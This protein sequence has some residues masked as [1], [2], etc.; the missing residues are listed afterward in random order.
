M[1]DENSRQLNWGILYLLTVPLG[2]ALVH[3]L[4]FSIGSF[5]VSGWMWLLYFL[6]AVLM[7]QAE[8]T[9]NRRWRID[10]PWHRW[11]PWVAF[12]WLSLIWC[13]GLG[14]RNVQDAMQISVP[15]VIA[16]VA[17]MFGRRT[18][19]LRLYFW[20]IAATLMILL[21]RVAMIRIHLI[22]D[23]DRT[24]ARIFSITAVFLASAAIALSHH[25]VRWGWLMWVACLV[26]AAGTGSRTTTGVILL[27]PVLDPLNRNWLLKGSLLSALAVVGVGLFYTPQFQ[28]RFFYDGHGT[29]T[30][31][32]HGD[33]LSFGRFEAW[34]AIYR[35][36]NEHCWFGAGVGEVTEFVPTV[37]PEEDKPHNDYLRL[38][39]ET[40]R[41]GFCLFWGTMILQYRDAVRRALNSTGLTKVA[42]GAAAL[43]I[44]GFAILCLTDNV[45]IYNLYYNNLL[46]A[47]LGLS[48]GVRRSQGGETSSPRTRMSVPVLPTTWPV[49]TGGGAT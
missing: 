7:F 37:W 14:Q 21:I 6:A 20:A 26:V 19:H 13:N 34:P 42:F 41:V 44:W 36:A 10:F 9:L 30:Q 48:Y 18:E 33:F 40:G 31:V 4:D 24:G 47:L 45:L 46:F 3:F 16:V 43:G 23:D 5:R 39:F 29:L 15:L 8:C 38:F 22:E 25:R 49:A 27:L 17:S 32:L 12:L 28:Q 1:R 2:A 35:K 11:L